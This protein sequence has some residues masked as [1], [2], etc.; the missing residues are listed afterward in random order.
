MA[1]GCRKGVIMDNTLQKLVEL[2]KYWTAAIKEMTNERRRLRDG[3][4]V[5]QKK[6]ERYYYQ[7]NSDGQIQGISRDTE[8]R[9]ELI[10]ARYLDMKIRELKACRDAIRVVIKKI[11]KRK[12]SPEKAIR[13]RFRDPDISLERLIWTEEQRECSRKQSENPYKREE[14]TVKTTRGIWM[15]SLSEQLIGNMYEELWIPYQYER[16]TMIDVT[17]AGDVG[18]SEMRNGKRYKV[19]YP[20]FTIILADGSTILH[21]HFGMADPE[22]RAKAGNKLIVLMLSRR[23]AKDRIIITGPEDA[24]NLERLREI[25]VTSILPDVVA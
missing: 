12:V 17:A 19:F 16:T 7:E 20:D 18:Y 9:D 5:V 2:E 14:L 25:A 3:S 13:K 21:E 8:R 1:K 15:R 6:G 22:Y 10:R 11:R 24:K 23:S 4:I